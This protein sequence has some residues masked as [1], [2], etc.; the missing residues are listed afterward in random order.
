MSSKALILLWILKSLNAAEVICKFDT[1]AFWGYTCGIENQT[2][3]DGSKVIFNIEAIDHGKSYNDVNCVVFLD[4]EIN[5]VPAELF[6]TFPFADRLVFMDNKFR[7]WRSDYLLGGSQMIAFVNAENLL[8]TLDDDSFVSVQNLLILAL[9]NNKIADI[10]PKAFKGLT[11]LQTL[12]LSGNQVDSLDE[13]LFK[14][15]KSLS[16]LDLFD[17]KLSLLPLG[18]FTNNRKLETLRLDGNKFTVIAAGVFDKDSNLK[19]LNVSNNL[20]F[21][22][23]AS[24][25]PEKL[26]IIYV[27]E[28][29]EL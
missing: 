10:S 6:N 14:D 17:N 27:G 7:K 12:Q 13:N 5:F 9:Y 11:K 23:E 24:V 20:I 25:L 28:L 8:E 1:L 29:T 3:A 22:I 19:S 21:S 26:Q 4:S 16:S 2:V 18:I 15:L